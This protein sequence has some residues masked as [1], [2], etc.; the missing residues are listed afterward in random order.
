M[1]N[2]Q[3]QND[4]AVEPFST[5][6]IKLRQEFWTHKSQIA[7]MPPTLISSQNQ[8]PSPSSSVPS[9]DSRIISDLPEMFAEFRGSCCYVAL[10][11]IHAEVVQTS[12]ITVKVLMQTAHDRSA[13]NRGRYRIS[14]VRKVCILATFRWSVQLTAM[15]AT[16]LDPYNSLAVSRLPGSSLDLSKK[17][18]PAETFR[19]AEYSMNAKLKQRAITNSSRIKEQMRAKFTNDFSELFTKMLTPFSVF[20]NGFE[21]F[22]LGG[23]VFGMSIGPANRG[24]IT[25]IPKFC[26]YS[27]KMNLIVFSRL[28]RS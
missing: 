6:F 13:Q 7:A 2:G 27:K 12:E 19:N 8:W 17:C 23:Q 28:P 22:T 26:H 1:E 5:S 3:T 9:F 10:C 18:I 16:S 11:L 20:I 14:G 4:P 15:T 21:Y 25:S 24:S